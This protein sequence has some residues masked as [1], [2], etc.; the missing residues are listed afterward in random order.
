MFIYYSD[1]EV[2]EFLGNTFPKDT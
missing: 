1:G 2:L